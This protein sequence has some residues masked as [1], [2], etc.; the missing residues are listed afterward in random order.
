MARAAE[1][2]ALLLR[3]SDG[4]GSSQ[5]RQ[6]TVEELRLEAIR[7]AALRQVTIEHRPDPIRAA[8]HF[9]AYAGF[10][11][12]MVERSRA[13]IEKSRASVTAS[14]KIC[15]HSLAALKRSRE[16]LAKTQGGGHHWA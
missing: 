1:W 4:M 5:L 13:L 11:S 15:S 10:G 16:V 7:A 14:R 3:R 6:I 12:H 8:G 9:S 2:R